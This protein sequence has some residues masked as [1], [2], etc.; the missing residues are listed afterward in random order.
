MDI[1]PGTRGM[2]SVMG[3]PDLQT[4]A[5]QTLTPDSAVGSAPGSGAVPTA[6]ALGFDVK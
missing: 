2:L 3:R 1:T 5:L 4:P 6:F